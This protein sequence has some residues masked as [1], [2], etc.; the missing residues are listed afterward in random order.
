MKK[1]VLILGVVLMFSMQANSQ[2]IKYDTLFWTS[3]SQDTTVFRAFKKAA[4]YVEID[5]STFADND[6]LTVGMSIDK[7]SLSAIPYG[8]DIFPMKITKNDYRS[9]VNG[10]TT[11][12]VGI[13]G[14]FWNAPYIG[15]R[16]KYA[17]SP[18]T[19]TPSIIYHQ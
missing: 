15:L 8:S 16:C 12:R 18:G 6:T 7:T 5:I 14:D 2:K 1:V 3:V 19:C 11:Y 13:Y 9:I 17:G 4:F 10:D